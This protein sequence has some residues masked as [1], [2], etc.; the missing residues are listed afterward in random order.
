[1]RGLNMKKAVMIGA[2]NIGRG[3]IGMLLEKSGYHV[4]FADI[5]KAV[6]DDIN[7][8][9][10]YTVHMVDKECVDTT[11]R[12]ISAVDSS[13]PRLA[14]EIAEAELICT[15]VGLTALPAIAPAI[16]N[17][18]ENRRAIGNEK[19]LNIIA[20]ENAVRGSSILKSYVYSA[21]GEAGRRYAEE[22]IG[23]PDSAVDRIIPPNRGSLA[24]DVVV[25]RYHEWDVERKG[26]RG[27]LPKIEGMEPVDDLTAYLERKLFT[28]NGPNAVTAYMG[29][30]KGYTTINEALTDRE[31]YET[32]Y[33]MME[34]CGRM[35][36]RRHGFD[37]GAMLK[38]R[39]LLLARFENPYIID[40]VVRVARE[41]MRKL[42]AN[43]RIIAPMIYAHEY[44]IETPHYYKGIAA[45]LLYNNPNDEQARRM[46]AMIA[47]AGL[48]KAIAE[49]CGLA[50]D[51]AEK[52]EA[53]YLRLRRAHECG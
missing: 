16:A 43:D 29:Y 23:F 46:Q 48:E 25:E 26:A 33:G 19:P 31:I 12:N 4:V 28:L 6:I 1:M 34:E 7:A 13:S 44:G 36:Q 18:I 22:Y 39:E 30:L 17:G 11:V 38:Y 51:D 40:D 5:S 53:E 47:E 37:A 41:P 9:H 50:G 42:A 35:L 27:N 14:S 3:F 52:V 20:C 10:E 24:A 32:V 49:I 15:A 8:R 45:A 21:L 2:G